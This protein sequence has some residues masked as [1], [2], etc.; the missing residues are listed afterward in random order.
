MKT[1]VILGC[2]NSTGEETRDWE[3]DPEYYTKTS[4][5]HQEWYNAKRETLLREYFKNNPD[6]L[7]HKDLT[8]S[9]DDSEWNNRLNSMRQINGNNQL[10]EDLS[11]QVHCDKHSWPALLNKNEEMNER[12]I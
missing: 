9:F 4:V 10:Q 12:K 5:S 6:K 7:L 1:I 2:S 3:L 11:W 8:G